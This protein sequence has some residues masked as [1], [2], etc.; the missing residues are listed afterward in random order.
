[1][2]GRT[3]QQSLPWQGRD[4]VAAQSSY[5]AAVQAEQSAKGMCAQLRRYLRACGARGATDAEIE[6][7][8]G[9][10]PNVSTARRNDLIDAG[11]VVV[12]WPERRRPSVKNPRLRVT[13]W[14]LAE[15]AR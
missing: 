1:M 14:I 12:A 7:D 8:L 6:R 13:V 3:P 5:E 4:P 2:H 15:C 9:W 10:P 11:E